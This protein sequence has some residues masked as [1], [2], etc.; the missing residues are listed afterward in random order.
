MSNVNVLKA[1]GK[2]ARESYLVK[3][4]ALN[5]TVAAQGSF[6]LPLPLVF[7]ANFRLITS[8]S[9]EM[10]KSIKN[11][12]IALL[13]MNLQKGRMGLGVHVVINDPTKLEEIKNREIEMAKEQIMKILNAGAN[14]V[15]TTKGIDD[16]C[17][18]YFVERGCMGVRRCK[19]EDLQ[20]IA[21]AT[22]G[23]L[24]STLANLDGEE[25]FDPACLGTA[26]EVLQTRIS[27]DE[28]VSFLLFLLFLPSVFLFLFSS[29][30]ILTCSL[31]ITLVFDAIRSSSTRPSLRELLPSSFV[32]PTR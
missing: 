21:K 24:I 15:L 22:G 13:D 12:K 31:I 25:S 20:R 6:L 28:L 1:H 27:D 29:F 26:G 11:A 30:S 23:T 7:H 9:S 19:K 17:L 18:K 2:S 16:L 32:G 10:P 4:Y 3:G 5:C 14:V 8:N